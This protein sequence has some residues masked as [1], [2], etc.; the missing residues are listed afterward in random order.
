MSKISPTKRSI[1]IK[2]KRKRKKK[3]QVLRQQYARA[4]M[5]LEKER[6]LEKVKK[7]APWLSKEEFLRPLK[8]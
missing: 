5:L 4:E 3:L 6:I 2:I 8:K 1:Q 7:I